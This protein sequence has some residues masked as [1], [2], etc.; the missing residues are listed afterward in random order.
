MTSNRRKSPEGLEKAGKRVWRA[1]LTEF[2]LD[3]RELLV[4]EQAA[5]QAD[6]VAALEAEIVDSGLLSRGSRGQTRLSPSVTEL[7]Q[8]R[9]ALSKLLGELALPDQD[10]QSAPSRRGRKAADARWGRN[11]LE[12]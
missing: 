5:R 1:I 12:S 7:R 2:D 6:A 11:G 10:E 9:L 4:L 3:E 8:S